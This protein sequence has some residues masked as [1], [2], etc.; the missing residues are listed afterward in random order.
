MHFVSGK[1]AREIKQSKPFASVAEEAFLNLGRTFEVLQEKVA[2]LLKE[3]QLTLPQ[4][5]ILRIL[6]GAP[7]GL[8]CSQI[9]ERMLTPDPDVTRL[10]DRLEARPLIARTRSQEDRRVVMARIT[11][12]GLEL[13]SQIDRPIEGLLQRML[14][15]AGKTRLKNLIE[16]LELLREIAA[17]EGSAHG[18]D[19]FK[20]GNDMSQIIYQIDSSHSAAHFSVRHMMI[21]NVRGEFTKVSGT[22]VYDPENPANSSV[23]AVIDAS[24]I[25][26]N[27]PQRDAHLRSPDFLDVERYPVLTFKSKSISGQRGEWKMTGDLTIRGITREV[28]LDVDGPTPEARDPWGGARIGATATG[29]I[30]RKDFGLTWNTV[31]ET[32]GVLVGDEVK[33]TLDI[34]GVRQAQK[35]QAQ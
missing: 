35:V 18:I 9:A 4:Y 11:P 17:E 28:T 3:Y 7:E 8:T 5:N 19:E 16:T 24:S 2:A 23:E 31:L 22:I 30:N 1:L 34:E 21:A 29:K 10:L 27:D 13:L 25:A 20:K 14:E 15:P 6:R 12:Y 26:T 32:G 33:L